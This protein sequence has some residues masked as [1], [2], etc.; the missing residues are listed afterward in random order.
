MIMHH[1][2]LIATCL[3]SSRKTKQDKK[4]GGTLKTF[5]CTHTKEERGTKILL[6]ILIHSCVKNIRIESKLTG[7]RCSCSWLFNNS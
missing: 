3:G 4:N 2:Y 1:S 7:S 6:L 5:G